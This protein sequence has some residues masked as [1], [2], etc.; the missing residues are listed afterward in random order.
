MVTAYMNVVE[1]A[2]NYNLDMRSAAF[3]FAVSK[4]IEILTA[5]GIFP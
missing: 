1:T 4:E 2:K 3:V 5:R